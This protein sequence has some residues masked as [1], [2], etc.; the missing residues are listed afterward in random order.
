MGDM[1]EAHCP[2]LFFLSFLFFSLNL[3]ISVTV[4]VT[5]LIFCM[6]IGSIDSMCGDLSKLM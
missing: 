3:S 6:Q 2:I 5:G 4:R 1:A